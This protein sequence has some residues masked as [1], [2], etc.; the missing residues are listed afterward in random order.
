M[1][2]ILDSLLPVLASFF[3]IA[4][5]AVNILE[6]RT[7]IKEGGTQQKSDIPFIM[8][9]VNACDWFLY[10]LISRVT[11]I[12]VSNFTGLLIAIYVVYVF[13]NYTSNNSAIRNHLMIAS[14][15]LGCLIVYIGISVGSENV[16]R[17]VGF[18]SSFVS[19]CMFASPLVTLK[20]VLQTKSTES[21]P[22]PMI[23][24]GCCCTFLWTWYGLRLDDVFVYVPNGIALC[25]GVL[26]V[27]LLI[28]FSGQTKKIQDVGSV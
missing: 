19:V 17:N 4:T 20:Q 16:V 5:Y 23:L 18:V 9:L 15:Y 8:L 25:L 21:L 7:I 28:V 2:S 14:L 24:V 22:A 11:A 6:A 13:Y 26:Q 27:L 1:G 3:A 12:L 10:G